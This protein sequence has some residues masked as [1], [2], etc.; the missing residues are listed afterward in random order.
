MWSIRLPGEMCA[1]VAEN[2][3]ADAV[4]LTPRLDQT[5]RW[6]AGRAE[7]VSRKDIP[8]DAPGIVEWW[9]RNLLAYGVG[10]SAETRWSASLAELGPL[11]LRTL[12]TEFGADY[13]ITTAFPPLPLTRVGPRNSKYAIYQLRA[14][15][16]NRGGE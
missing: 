12:A 4:F 8:Q 6:Y 7:V 11:R 2:T 15:V 13:V 16:E 3:P 1:W 5:F 9:R 14:D 10:D